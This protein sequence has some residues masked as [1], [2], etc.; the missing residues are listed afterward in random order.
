MS[1]GINPYNTNNPDKFFTT[2]ESSLTGE[3][4][5]MTDPNCVTGYFNDNAE[6]QV[7]DVALTC[8]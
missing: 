8:H 2:Y 1:L 7:I 3:V 4:V 5:E 6:C